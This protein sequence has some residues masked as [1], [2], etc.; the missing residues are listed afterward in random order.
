[1]HISVLV[2]IPVNNR[3]RNSELVNIRISEKKFY[4]GHHYC[5]V[6]PTWHGSYML[7][8]VAN[9][10][11]ISDFSTPSQGH[12]AR[13]TAGRRGFGGE[14]PGAQTIFLSPDSITRAACVHELIT[15]TLEA[16]TGGGAVTTTLMEV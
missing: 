7:H 2:L 14:G 11:V 1:M 4:T 8:C 16:V 6:N 12:A 10:G 13:R 9:G 15:G 3:I 5:M